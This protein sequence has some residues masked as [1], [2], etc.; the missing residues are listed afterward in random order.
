MPAKTVLQKVLDL[1]GK[2]VTTHGGK[3]G[4]AEW[5]EFLASAAAQGVAV[6]DE[7]KR[8]LGNILETSK[9]FYAMAPNGPAKKAAAKPKRKTAK[10]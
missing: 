3:W 8:N 1:A 5:E 4:H 10:S 7:S 6:T 2:F 9:Y